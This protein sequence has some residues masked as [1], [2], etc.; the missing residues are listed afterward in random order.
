M[1]A[2]LICQFKLAQAFVVN[3]IDS[4]IIFATEDTLW[5]HGDK[6]IVGIVEI[7]QGRTCYK[8]SIYSNKNFLAIRFELKISNYNPYGL[9]GNRW[10]PQRNQINDP[11]AST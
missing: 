10:A 6:R 5:Q 1:R 2:P 3:Q 11:S 8:P 9:F 7:Y 4:D